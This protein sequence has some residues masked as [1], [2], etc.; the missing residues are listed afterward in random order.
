VGSIVEEGVVND[1]N[2]GSKK[3]MISESSNDDQNST[4]RK[5][6]ETEDGVKKRRSD[7]DGVTSAVITVSKSPG[8][9][10][11]K[12]K[13]EFPPLSAEKMSKRKHSRVQGTGW[14]ASKK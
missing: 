11:D 9:L 4:R 3:S 6:S 13:E 8:T 10:G 1:D 7:E 14:A 2:F 12:Y 5:S